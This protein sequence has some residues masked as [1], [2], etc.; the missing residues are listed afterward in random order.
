MKVLPFFTGRSQSLRLPPGR[1]QQ[2]GFSLFM[3]LIALV[4]LLVATAAIMRSSGL[5]LFS[6]GNLAFKQDAVARADLVGVRVFS[7]FR[8]GA[9]ANN[10]SLSASDASQNYSAMVL[11]RNAQGI[12]LALVDDSAFS[13]AGSS[14]NDIADTESNT[15]I[16]YVIERLCDQVGDVTLNHCV[17][18]PDSI[19]L[20]NTGTSTATSSGGGLPLAAVGNGSYPLLR[21]TIRVRGARGSETFLQSLFL[22]PI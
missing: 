8:T 7:L 11:P 4:I 12:P 13:G 3:T 21:V 10:A 14:S 9:L 16:R 1:H 6:S 19:A 5:N 22:K 2:R 20:R 15:T 17:Y 18:D